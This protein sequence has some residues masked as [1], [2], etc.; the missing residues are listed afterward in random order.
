LRG[1]CFGA[2]SGRNALGQSA[3]ANSLLVEAEV[4]PA[5]VGVP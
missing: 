1:V 3:S 2:R 5:L 4:A